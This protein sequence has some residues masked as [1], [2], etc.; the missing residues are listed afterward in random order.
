MEAE[1]FTR[2]QEVSKVNN[3]LKQTKIDL[4][5]AHDDLERQVEERTASLA[6]SNRQLQREID[7]RKRTEQEFRTQQTRV[8]SLANELS[9]AEERE[10]ARIAGELHDHVG[11]RLLLGKLKID[12]VA[13]Q[14]PSD[15]DMNDIMEITDLIGQSIQDIR[16]LTFQLRP[17]I[18]STAGLEAAV[19]WL[20][21]EMHE[22]LGLDVELVD[23]KEP[24]PLKYEIRSALFQATRELLLN[25]AK[26]AGTKRV[27]VSLKKE[28]GFIVIVV[29]D[30]GVGFD[31]QEARTQYAKN[32]GFG[33]FNIEQRI[34]YMEGWGPASR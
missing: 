19:R 1:I 7:E 4:R 24:K 8:Q 17:P 14:S 21:K 12:K 16:S 33:L 22:N 20:G 15:I 30:H 34:E 32:N 2:C 6:L 18:L 23:D 5:K 11:H 29:E 27:N 13:N 3:L 25:V 31:V 26:H 9:I 10:R 28:S